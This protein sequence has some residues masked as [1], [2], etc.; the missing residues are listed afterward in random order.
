MRYDSGSSLH[1]PKHPATRYEMNVSVTSRMGKI[2]N[3]ICF[4]LELFTASETI[5]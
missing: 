3:L 4:I 5:A 2:L 1:R